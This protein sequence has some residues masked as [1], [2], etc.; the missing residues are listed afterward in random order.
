MRKLQQALAATEAFPVADSH[1]VPVGRTGSLRY[2]GSPFFGHS[3]STGDGSSLGNGLAALSQPFKLR[4]AAASHEKQLVDYSVNV[5]RLPSTLIFF[6]GGVRWSPSSQI[7]EALSASCCWIA[8]QHAQ[9]CRHRLT[10]Q[11]QLAQQPV[12]AAQVL[13]DT[14]ASLSAVEDFLYGKVYRSAA[15]AEQ[16]RAAAEAAAAAA[17]QKVCCYV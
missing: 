11:A 14:M 9:A 4:L 6:S 17:R 10:R 15:A 7:D 5:V 1:E 12:L 8:M 2:G 16:A 3:R 13:I